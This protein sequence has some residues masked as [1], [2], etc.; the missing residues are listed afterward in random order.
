MRTL[1]DLIPAIVLLATCCTPREVEQTAV[2]APG[3]TSFCAYFAETKTGYTIDESA[4]KAVF[5]WLKGDR[6]DVAVSNGSTF[7]PVAFAAEESGTNVTFRDGV[8]NANS[9]SSIRESAPGAVL[10]DW[11][12]YPSLSDPA[13]IANNYGIFWELQN[14]RKTVRLPQSY[15]YVSDNPLAPVPLFGLRDSK[16]DY[17]FSPMTAV[18]AVPVS[19]ITKDMDFISISSEKVALS[20]EF[21][22]QTGE[23]CGTLLSCEPAFEADRTATIEFKDLEGDYTFYFCIPAGTVPAG[24]TIACG[25]VSDPAGQLKLTTSAPATFTRGRILRCQQLSFG[26]SSDWEVVTT[27]GRFLDDFLWSMHSSFTSGVYI[28]V[29][30]ER[31]VS[32]PATF[33]IANPYKTA[34]SVFSYT[35]HTEGIVADPYLVFTVASDGKITFDPFRTGIEDKDTGGRPIML[36]HAVTWNSSR[37]GKESRVLWFSSMDPTLP[38]SAQLACVYSDPDDASYYYTR[39]GEGTSHTDRVHILFSDEPEPQETWDTVGTGRFLDEFFWKYNGFPPFAV[40]V[41]VSRSS[42]NPDNYRIP[43][44]YLLANKAFMRNGYSG[45]EFLYFSIDASGA[46]SYE[47]FTTGMTLTISGTLNDRN[48]AI[49]MGSNKSA[50]KV[51]SGS[52]SAPCEIQMGS[53]YYD[54]NDESHYYTR[55]TY[56]L[57]HLYF[58]AYY[59]GETWT[60]F[61]DG[62]YSDVTY[63]KA[64]NGSSAIGSVPVVIQRSSLDGNRYRIANPYRNN[65]ESSLLR[66][67]YDEYLYFNTGAGDLVFFETFRPGLAMNPS[68]NSAYELGIAHPA[69]SNLLGYSQGGSDFTG[70]SVLGT[71]S[72]GTPKKV[73]LGA[74]YYDIAG[75]TPGYCYTRQG[76]AWPNDRIYI[77][78][79]S[80]DAV[81]VE[82][83]RIPVRPQFHN[84][85]AFL[86]IPSGTL[87]KM[88]V[89]VIGSDLSKVRGLRLYQ[90]GW[91]DSG[92]VAPDANGIITMTSFTNPTISGSVDLNFWI[93]EVTIG[94]S[95]RFDIQEVVV[96]GES[97]TVKQDNT[98]VHTPGVVVN[99]GGDVENVRGSAE[100]VA[101]FRIPALVTSNAGTL[102]AAYDVRYAHSGDLQADIDVGMKRSTDGGKT[103]SDLKLIM[104]MGE[105]G[106]LAQNQNGIGDPCLLVD[107]NT[108][109]IF[110]F[111]VWTHGHL[112]DSDPRSLAWASTGYEIAET[113]QFMMVY[114]DDDG[115][116]WTAPINIT[117]QVKLPEWRM[118]FQG[119]GRGITMKDGTLVVPIQHQEGDSKIMHNL[120]PLNSGIMYSKDHG[121]TWHATNLAHTVTSECAVAEIEPGVLMLSM[122]D[123]TDSHYR[124]VFT[125]T[126]LG[127][128]WTAHSTNGKVYEQSACEASLLHV[129]A[130]ANSLGQDILLM[131]N[132]QGTEGWRSAITIQASLD[133]G[134]TWTH[135]YLLDPGGSLGYS[136]LT[137]IDEN[138]VGVLYE[139]P[140]ASILFQAVPL[141]DIIR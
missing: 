115:L 19:G 52:A 88:V 13:A 137:M 95:F 96:S 66:S 48:Y 101:S 132:P 38:V 83:N 76:T 7:L 122:R 127:V 140:R 30:I 35:P 21:T 139:S 120:Y 45:D 36:N 24:L 20:G 53:V 75:P 17:A 80:D 6:I 72:D 112:Y 90:A 28:P 73:Q 91:M 63:D 27:D 116:T 15:S 141:S 121:A 111:A 74:H 50:T 131:S 110:C 18:L 60:D 25:C 9:L 34:C 124:R 64:I 8:E 44:P 100:T 99:N 113:P 108:G 65:V 10:S 79:N 114:S 62:T 94:S 55:D 16:G 125:T 51:V 58:P 126:D 11:A 105:Y 2:P 70:S 89:K 77:S 128:S 22:L 33:R 56:D 59:S 37:T 82:H 134:A 109:R 97:F 118:T 85:V 46:V 32:N 47:P 86:S 106:G 71:K 43:N 41:E 123:E 87:Q 49:K 31:S 5:S 129:D 29:T 117:T 84:P 81:T 4:K 133:H 138:T 67:A 93:D 103:W 130:S 136:C 23:D 40:P 107:E 135:K 78:F 42:N 3:S 102:I 12:F 54:S 119:P 92:Y 1:F 39:D 61:S 98:I 26:A 69:G 57:K 104:D 14:E 68:V